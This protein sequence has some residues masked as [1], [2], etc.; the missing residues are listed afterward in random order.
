[1]NSMFGSIANR[2]SVQF[3]CFPFSPF[4]SRVLCMSV[5]ALIRHSNWSI[6]LLTHVTIV[7]HQLN[8]R[9]QA[10][11]DTKNKTIRNT[12]IH[13][14]FLCS[15]LLFSMNVFF[16]EAN[17][18]GGVGS[19]TNIVTYLHSKW[20]TSHK[21]PIFGRCALVFSCACVCLC[22]HRQIDAL[23]FVCFSTLL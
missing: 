12:S 11:T 23:N 10:H 6:S 19:I 22:L 9:L 8:W 16:N 5:R 4:H 14:F 20:C 3:D 18:D 21:M 1:M 17:N 13:R 15:N 7:I 2:T